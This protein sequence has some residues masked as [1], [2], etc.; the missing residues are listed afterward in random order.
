M[1][2]S[3]PEIFYQS[4]PIIHQP[5]V[6]QAAGATPSKPRKLFGEISQS[7]LQSSALLG[8]GT[9]AAIQTSGTS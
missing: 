7:A 1:I 3:S 5:E 9:G 4:I 6:G 2:D 8:Q